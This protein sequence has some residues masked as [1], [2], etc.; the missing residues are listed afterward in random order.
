MAVCSG[1]G[2]DPFGGA[3]GHL[4]CYA[5][6]IAPRYQSARKRIKYHQMAGLKRREG[7]VLGE[8]RFAP[9]REERQETV[10]SMREAGL[11][12]RAI[13]AATGASRPTVISDVRSGGQNLTGTRF[14][15]IF[16]RVVS[17]TPP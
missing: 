7:G 13:S 6:Q 15:R 3:T 8:P 5:A 14:G 12:I 2:V 11:S 10:R 4:P 17:F 9:P 16:G 1:V